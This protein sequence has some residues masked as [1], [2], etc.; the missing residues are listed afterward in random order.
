MT[1][2]KAAGPAPL[3]DSRADQSRQSITEGHARAVSGSTPAEMARCRAAEGED[4]IWMRAQFGVVVAAA[5]W[6]WSRRVAIAPSL[7]R[8]HSRQ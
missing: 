8:C 2:E 4:L 1:S 3:G 7:A 5:R 6:G